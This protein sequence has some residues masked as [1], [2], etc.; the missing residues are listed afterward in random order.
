V[1]GPVHT[2]ASRW[3][4]SAADVDDPRVARIFAA[5]DEVDNVL[6]GPEF[7]AVGVQHPDR[8]EQLL[9]PMLR[10][11]ESAFPPVA[12]AADAPQPT[13][14]PVPGM[15]T[16]GESGAAGAA[17]P[18][19]SA[20]ERL[21]G[22]DPTRRRS[23][24]GPCR[25]GSDDLHERQVARDSSSARRRRTAAGWEKLL[26]DPSRIVRARSSTR[27]SMPNASRSALLERALADADA[28]P[29][30]GVARLVEL[31]VGPSRTAVTA[32]AEDADFRARL[33]AAG[34]PVRVRVS[35]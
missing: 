31:G 18:R 10:L 34:A 7:V 9:A 16:G 4:D 5:F 32:L 25:A 12:G 28:G 2:G 19:S 30:E 27:W 14:P 6:V 24:P 15:R 22:L 21:G 1:T 3:Y 26:D 35:G 20:V 13:A 29:M 8:W 33:E 23:G 11:V 17:A